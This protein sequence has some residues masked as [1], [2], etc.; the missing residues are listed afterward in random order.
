MMSCINKAKTI[1]R[2]NYQ[3]QPR[4]GG[5]SQS[6]NRMS[7]TSG[8]IARVSYHNQQKDNMSERAKHERWK[9]QYNPVSRSIDPSEKER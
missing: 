4:V 3:H 9:L 5:Q 6:G 1:S 2:Q 8:S 7:V